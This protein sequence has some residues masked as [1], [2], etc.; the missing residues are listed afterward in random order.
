VKVLYLDCFAGASGDMFVGALL[1]LG[2]PLEELERGL[3]ALP[4]GGYELRA[5]KERRHLL[6]GTRFEVILH[7]SHG[8]GAHDAG[9]HGRTYASI[10]A[11][12][13]GARVPDRARADALSVFR[14]LAEAE[15]RVHGRPVDD[16]HFH[17]VGA[18]DSIV[19]IVGACLGLSGLGVDRL[20]A[21]PP[22]TGSGFV[23]V[24]HGRLPVPAPATALLLEG[25]PARWGEGEGEL[26]T[27]TGAALLTTLAV[28]AESAPVLDAI[29]V[30]HGIGSRETGDRPNALRAVLGTTAGEPSAPFL[31]DVVEVL[32]T[33]IDDASGEALAHLAER[34][35]AAGALDVALAP[36]FMKKGRPGTGLTI[37]AR[38]ADAGPLLDVLFRESTTLGV[39]RRLERRA[40]LARA[41]EV[42]ETPLGACRVKVAVLPGGGR[43]PS[44]EFDDVRRLAVERGLPLA[45]VVEIV[46]RAWAAR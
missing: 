7:D 24:E 22:A 13:A 14:R 17:E 46:L 41:I 30:G 15:A 32:E 27:P 18:V 38:P 11:M 26:L 29:R 21:S 35:L 23:Q 44:P 3:A 28:F 10:R 20:V 40:V 25:F 4:V 42:V 34:L 8:D 31:E 1:D 43:R 5:R 9:A 19:D 16:V 6:E 37:L 39:R 33:A 12:L 36:V 45:E 2:Y